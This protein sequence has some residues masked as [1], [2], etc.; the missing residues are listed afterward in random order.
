MLEPDV[1]NLID[2]A[3]NHARRYAFRVVDNPFVALG[4]LTPLSAQDRQ[5]LTALLTGTVSVADWR[6][7]PNGL[8]LVKSI[9]ASLMSRDVSLGAADG[10]GA[11]GV[12]SVHAL[13]RAPHFWW[14]V[15]HLWCSTVG[16]S[17]ESLFPAR[18]DL[19]G[20]AIDLGSEPVFLDG[21]RLSPEYRADPWASGEVLEHHRVGYRRW[22][23]RP[24]QFS[25]G[26]GDEPVSVCR[27]DLKDFY[28]S[29]RASPTEI[30]AALRR[31]AEVGLQVTRLETTLTEL[32]DLLHAAYAERVRTLRPRPDVPTDAVPLPVGPPSSRVLANAIVG[33]VARD[34]ID[35]TQI[36]GIA[37]YADDMVAVATVHPRYGESTADYLARLG[38]VDDA[39]ALQ[40][41]RRTAALGAFVLRAEKT[42]V[43]RLRP[44]LEDG[45]DS[46]SE[47]L[48]PAGP[49][50]PNSPTG[51][52]GTGRR[53]HPVLRGARK[54]RGAPL[55]LQRD[56][57]KM[58]ADARVGADPSELAGRLAGFLGTI[59]AAD[60]LDLRESWP[61]LALIAILASGNAGLEL[62]F[63]QFKGVT[64]DLKVP[65]WLSRDGGRALTTGLE[66]AWELAIAQALA[67]GCG[68]VE[69]TAW[70][71]A[72][73]P[74]GVDL[75][76]RLRT[77]RLADRLRKQSA[78][79]PA[80]V[81][82]PLSEFTQY[83][84]RLI[85]PETFETFIAW[86]ARRH[87]TALPTQMKRQLKLA[88]RPVRLHEACLA[89]HSYAVPSPQGLDGKW[90]AAVF[91]LLN[92][93]PLRDSEYLN[94]LETEVRASLSVRNGA[95]RP[96]P[97]A[98]RVLRIAIPSVQISSQLLT[99][100]LGDDG[101]ERAQLAEASRRAATAVIYKAVDDKAHLLVMPEWSLRPELLPWV[102]RKAASRQMYTVAGQTPDIRGGVYFNRVW[103]GIPLIIDSRSECLV[104]PPRIK[105]FLS[106]EEIQAL[107]EAEPSVV[108]APGDAKISVYSWR[109]LNVGSLICF[110]FADISTRDSLRASADVV[111][112]SSFN[113]DW[114]YFDAIQDATTRDL[115][116]LS[117]CVNAGQLPGTRIGRPTS[118]A[119]ATAAAIHG[120]DRPAV[121]V[122]A[123]DIRPIIAARDSGQR[124]T[125]CL[126]KDGEDGQPYR[127]VDDVPL[128]S[129]SAVPPQLAASVGKEPK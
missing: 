120:A 109:G 34:L 46:E 97:K 43:S 92:A 77:Q 73:T 6:S 24:E 25:P 9:R 51:G 100:A 80:F 69:R 126:A 81:A 95:A 124:P 91:E 93:N 37:A 90:V 61:Q 13:L 44:R 38:V 74:S 103:T 20:D 88:A 102:M 125:K 50:D 118:S 35:R 68:D 31:R 30:L 54:P 71:A 15:S 78:V 14:L 26:V 29:V 123:I 18:F 117:V 86:A 129:Y 17:A 104:P 63:E 58:L 41:R 101:A 106:P 48:P 94:R 89:V 32:L 23:R 8:R 84:G 127:P 76:F 3:T 4:A 62:L 87:R 45:G 98:E 12:E 66:A 83:Q 21:Q 111:T 7:S 115:Y 99:A 11:V 85:G 108:P 122:R 1:E 114:R 39:E 2:L 96:D 107:S 128:R 49:F 57:T 79:N 105:T 65:A 70:G 40:V 112:V 27:F 121:L 56:L 75:S 72:E 10:T 60:F 22:K 16:R 64:S 53:L 116:C 52:L 42:E 110:E 59:D 28:Y 119:M 19:V 55:A 113:K 47:P 36:A 5:D 67:A 82:V 33:L